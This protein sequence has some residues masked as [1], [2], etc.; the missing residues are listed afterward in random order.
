MSSPE[1]CDGLDGAENVISG[2]VEDVAGGG[3]DT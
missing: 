1:G 2:K 3:L